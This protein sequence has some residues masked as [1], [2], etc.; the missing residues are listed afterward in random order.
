MA[1]S[2]QEHVSTLEITG[3]TESVLPVEVDSPALDGERIVISGVSGLF[4]Q[5][6]NVKELSDIL[7]NKENPITSEGLRW[8]YK[9][10]DLALASGMAP[11]LDLFD[12]QFFTVYYRLGNYMDPMSRKALEQT[13]QALYDAGVSPAQLSGKKV[14]VFVGSSFSNTEKFGIGECTSRHGLGIIGSSKTMYANRISY[15]LN[16]KGPSIGIDELD[17][18]FT[19]ALEAAYST[20]RRG[21]CEAAIVGGASLIL[22]PH[23][24]LHHAKLSATVSKDGNTKSFSQDADGYVLSDTVGVV[25]LQ[26]AKDAK[27]VYAELLHVKNEFVS[28]LTDE[29]GPKFGYSQNPQTTAGFIRQFYKEVQVS[30]QAVEYVEAYGTGVPDADKYEL[31]TIDEVYCKH[32]QDPLLVGSVT[33]NIG[34]TEAAS[35][36]AAMTKVLL[37]YHTGKLAANLHC[38][39]PRQDV[40]ALRD[41]RIRIVNE[42]QPFNRSY[43]ALNGMSLTGVNSHVLLHG[44]YKPKDLSRYQSSIPRLVTLSGR[45]ESAIKKIFDN[46]KS[47]PIDAEEIALLHNI[48]GNNISGHLG[49]GY[50]ILDTNENKE[51]VSLREKSE[52]FDDPRRPLWF[53]YSGMGSQW[54]GMGAQLM[55]IP[56]FAAAIERCHKVLAPLGFDIVHIITSSDKTVLE[57]IQNSFVG[58]AAIQI[59]LTDVLHELGLKPDGII[60][61]SVGELAC[62]YADGCLTAEET[63]LCALYRGQV[64]L[65]TPLIKGSMAAVGLGYDQVSKLCPPEVDVACHNGPGSSTISGPADA[66][67]AFVA[68]LTAKGVFAKEVP[69]ANIAYHSRYIAVAG[70]QLLNLLNGVITNPK[71]RSERWLSTS[72]PEDRWN[73]LSAQ[74]CSAEY[75]TNNL[76]SPVLFEETSR[77]IPSNAVCV[78]VAPHG[79]LQAILKKSMPAESRHVPLT[80]RGHP[81]NALFLLEAVGE[82]YMHGYLPQVQALYPKVEFPVSSETPMLSHLVE[83]NHSEIWK[84]AKFKS[85]KTQVAADCQ[86]VKSIHDDEYSYL[87][88]HVVREK[89]CY[90]FAAALVSV[91]DTLAMHSGEKKRQVPVKFSDVHLYAQPTLHDQRPLK[92]NVTLHRGNGKFEVLSENSKVASGY[93][94]WVMDR[95]PDQNNDTNMVLSSK[96]IY[97]LLQDRDY[98]YSGEFVSIEAASESLDQAALIWRDN[99]V[100]FIDGLL[101]MNMLRQAHDAVSQPTQIR[102]LCLDPRT[103]LQD[104]Y[105]L[106]GKTVI[107][108]YFSGIHDLTTCGGVTLQNIKYRNLP[109]ISQDSTR[110]ELVVPDKQ[111]TSENISSAVSQQQ[112]GLSNVVTLQSSRIGDLDSL[113][114]V[115]A[116]PMQPSD[117]VVTVHYAGLCASDVK[118]AIGV[119]PGD[120]SLYGMD[121]SGTT[122]SGERV[123]GIVHSGSASSVVRAQPELLWPVPAHWSLEDAAT[124][125]LAYVHALYCLVIKG[126]I[127]PGNDVLIH[128]GTG[129]LGQA[130]IAVALAYG[131]RVFTTVSDYRKK[132][133][134]KKLYPELKDEHIGN[135]RDDNFSDNVLMATKGKGCRVVLCCV[136]GQIKS[137]SLRCISYSGILVD[138]VQLQD[139]EEF[140]LGMHFM[141]KE[142]AYVATDL[143]SIFTQQ[144]SE[145]MKYLQMMLSEGI[146][147]GYV[148]PLSRVSYAPHEAT[149]AFR[150]LAASK[151]RGRVLL[152][153]QDSVSNIYPRIICNP[154]ESHLMFW[155]DGVLGVHLAERLVQRGAKKLFIH[156]TSLNP[157]QQYKISSWQKLGVEVI[158][159]EN[160]VDINNN[161]TDIIKDATV[162]GIIEG[163]FV[164]VTK[165]ADDEN[166]EK[167][168]TF[169]NSIDA[170]SRSLWPDLKYFAVVS[171]VSSVGQDTCIARAKCGFKATSLDVSSLSKASAHDLA[172]AVEQA[173]RSTSSVLLA[174]PAHPPS[175]DMLE[176]LIRLA[177]ISIPQNTNCDATLQELGM[178][179]AKIPIISSFLNIA[180]NISLEEDSISKL[181]LTKLR[182]LEESASDIVPKNVSG[183]S[184]FF[185]NVAKDELLATTDMVVVPTLYKDI[186]LSRDEFDVS[187]R[188]L[189]IVPGMEGHHQRFDVLCEHLKLPA[190]VLQPGLDHPTET[191]QETAQRYAKTLIN[192]TR[193]QNNFY[194]LGYETGVLVAL[195]LAAILEDHGLTG[196]V[197]CVGGL[198]EDL[199][200]I[201]EEQLRDLK[202]E[203]QLQDSVIRHMS[204][205]L[206]GEDIAN[207]D[208][209]LRDANNWSEKV[210][211]C[212]RVLLGRLQHSVQYARG[213]IEAALVSI[214]RSRGYV[215]LVRALNSQLVLLRPASGNTTSSAQELQRYSQRPIAIHQLRT[216]L[217]FISNDMEFQAIINRYLDSEIKSEFENNN[218]C[219]TYNV[220]MY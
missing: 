69:T 82:L 125:P 24:A 57:N 187:K 23:G 143:S 152:R 94:H 102:K 113:R 52:Y 40:V 209:V 166:K 41:G 165:E 50:I 129:A 18:S 60:G 191:V 178:A 42:H 14:A 168:T 126:R 154:E 119:T 100:T 90:P 107:N 62:A 202:T 219:H 214:K 37:G 203:E 55:R 97:Q 11:D 73:E 186:T 35:G 103:H 17:C 153:M 99:W 184:L 68:E 177:G 215:P 51:T 137:A 86:F 88:G 8:N 67:K 195:E 205:L 196:T 120:S 146:G 109:P 115:E 79:L 84:V 2:P 106:N 159:L 155:D 32:R 1:P 141:T 201:I 19:T 193:V 13:Y 71:Q 142:R 9:H 38:E 89:L 43:V 210:D 144:K 111:S 27:R 121:Y 10:P 135:S 117:L 36:M 122:E 188:Y 164:T 15:W 34:L 161:V 136:K 59:G 83:W 20:L 46:L 98:N 199:Q 162:L 176:Q 151:H 180:Y 3:P 140:E 150:L 208:E 47:R 212:V 66:M 33:S 145:E 139:R 26:K 21:E 170:V 190:L 128:G 194:L 5:S 91:W 213:L 85:G 44:R 172:D 76:L 185:S 148:R 16:V 133:F 93:I 174:Q 206:V 110:V 218:L 134:L 95:N 156:S 108:A 163:I 72:V 63:I 28:L 132:E 4:P 207:L 65:N 45:Q 25:L 127:L 189:C 175:P 39:N 197:F 49:R 96:D 30:P 112:V 173:L 147:R 75:Q 216:P 48:H 116:A 157:Y 64:S 87:R 171:T 123:M 6:H 200:E 149:R 81:D 105:S 31:E 220:L 80:R 53:V 158:S 182:E 12:A 179:D 181:T 124:V 101:Q 70:P 118:R 167:L 198:P 7:Y 29:T 78:E 160:K 192:K 58:I 56:V 169:I 217:S 104:T 61:H 77:L 130:A 183:I 211:A 138:T 22:H 92:L 131:C 54:A 74:Y 114:W 204:K